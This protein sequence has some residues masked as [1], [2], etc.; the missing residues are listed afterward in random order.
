MRTEELQEFLEG[1]KAEIDREAENMMETEMPGIT[2]ELFAI[3]EQT[4][5]RLK[6]EAV[7]F[8]RR[9]LLAVFGLKALVE[10]QET[11]RV[12]R[13][14]LKKLEEIMNAT[15]DEECWALPAHVDRRENQWQVTVDL[16]AAETG[17]TL[18]E[19]ADRL[20]GELS[21]QLHG[22]IVKNIEWRIF[23]PFFTS[24]V[25]YR[26]WE[27]S[28][29]NW[30]AVCAGSIGSACLHLMRGQK[31]Y[32]ELCLERICGSL[33]QYVA[34]FAEDGACMEGLGYF[35]YGMTYFVNFARELYE[36]TEG[37]MDLLTGDWAGFHQGG[38]DKRA[39][40]AAFQGKCY[41]AD[42]R[43]VSFSD[44]NSRDRF[45]VG[46]S[47]ALAD[48]FPQAQFPNM[49]RAAGLLG[50]NCYRFAA[51]KM[52]LFETQRFLE[53][54]RGAG[55]GEDVRDG[56]NG[57]AENT[58]CGGGQSG[59]TLGAGKT[60]FDIL[61]DA[62]WCIG[63]SE[64]GAGMACKGGHN[65]EP[66]NHND[67]GHFLYEAHGEMLFT[68]LGSGEY[69]RDYFGE[70]RYDILCNH[71]F[72]HSVPIID[73][74]GQCAGREYACREFQAQL[75]TQ[76]QDQTQAQLRTQAQTQ[77]QAQTQTQAQARTQV[78]TQ[79]QDQAWEGQVSME[80]AGAYEAGLIRS[81]RRTLQFSLKD[82]SLRVRDQFE[83]PR[84]RRGEV[85]ENLVTQIPPVIRDGKVLLCSGGVTG[86]LE[87]EGCSAQE[88]ISIKEYQHSNHNG[89]QE[90]V[91]AVQW[92][93]PV[94]AADTG[95]PDEG[96]K[97]G[98][99]FSI[100]AIKK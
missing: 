73:G 32:L 84:G 81:L 59:N 43:T 15:C 76:A 68:D 46:L 17:Q 89:E 34:G 78:Q 80:L 100:S 13:S 49:E 58:G 45:R 65:D 24:P 60:G 62:Q 69:T 94:T 41:F 33:P 23:R 96:G 1:F 67:I 90:K 63:N 28:E 44:G 87:I 19:L 97:A 52:D 14:V 55:D 85:V 10:K 26:N 92:K 98:C 88:D 95:N 6:Y 27:K 11:G 3:Y 93:V 30:N 8:T 79:A 4:G 20:A 35:T 5:N 21:E 47:C 31:E 99:C 36:Y 40:M 22:R 82:G 57:N 25:P 9:K 7:Y 51:L 86:I 38:S 50:D 2:E 16:F 75:R 71:S 66:H 42:G 64:S 18:A 61:P 77:A 70:K 39:R 56:A 12:S 83:F 54:H 91:Y 48:C 37:K 29:N 53:R 74:K 72:G